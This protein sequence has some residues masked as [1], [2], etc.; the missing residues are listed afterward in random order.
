MILVVYDG[1]KAIIIIICFFLKKKRGR[2]GK[3]GKEKKRTDA[4][5]SVRE[6]ESEKREIF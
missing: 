6:R 2:K 5:V 3:K 1:R 4:N